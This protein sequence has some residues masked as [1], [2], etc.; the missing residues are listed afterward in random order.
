M[1]YVLQ[2]ARALAVVGLALQTSAFAADAPPQHHVRGTLSR[3]APAVITV[4]TATGSV[5]VPVNAKTRVVGVVRASSSDITSGTFIGTANVAG[6][7]AARALEVVIFPKAMA[8]T[9]EGDYAWDL[10]ATGR[11]SMMTNGTV[12][13]SGGGHSMMTNATVSNITGSGVKTVK[14]TYKGGT[15]SVMIPADA[16]IVR[17]VPGTKALLV[18]GAHV[19]VSL[20]AANGPARAIIVG[21]GVVPPM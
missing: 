12:A 2:A 11:P 14:L 18:T 7:G 6:T 10:P 8:G 21:E 4:T 15:K 16:P 17:I 5:D 9:G 1:K 3:V 19:V 20:S 13:A